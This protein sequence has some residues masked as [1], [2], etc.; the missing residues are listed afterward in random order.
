MK[1]L[2]KKITTTEYVYEGEEEA[3]PHGFKKGDRVT[4]FTGEPGHKVM[5]TG[6]IQDFHQTDNNHALVKFD[7]LAVARFVSVETL[8][9]VKYG[10][11]TPEPHGFNVGDRIFRQTGDGNR[12][13]KYGTIQRF[14][15]YDKNQAMV[16]F[17]SHDV[18]R[19][20]RVAVLEKAPILLFNPGDRVKWWSK[21]DKEWQNGDVLVK[22]PEDQ[23]HVEDHWVL[24][25]LDCRLHTSHFR[26]GSL[27]HTLSTEAKTKWNS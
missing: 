4:Q 7:R 19:F 8:D 1:R 17:D 10:S 15:D 12:V 23:F 24:V 21:S 5:Q 14:H 25:Q 26:A 16:K 11:L 27:L 3:E 22:D 2:L 20:V 18:A 13:R 9:K 6:T